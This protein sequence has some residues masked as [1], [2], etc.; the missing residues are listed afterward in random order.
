MNE[1]FSDVQRSARLVAR[2][3]AHSIVRPVRPVGRSVVV[4]RP[5]GRTVVRSV[6][7]SVVRSEGRSVERPESRHPSLQPEVTW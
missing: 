1:Q 6:G 2:L 7:R 5:V 4:V 3:L